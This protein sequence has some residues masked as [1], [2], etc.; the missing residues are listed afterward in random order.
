MALITSDFNHNHFVSGLVVLR[1]GQALYELS[2]CTMALITSDSVPS[3]PSQASW[4]FEEGKHGGTI[5]DIAI[6]GIDLVRSAVGESS[7]IY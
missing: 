1:G 2:S 7:V 4:Y 3:I 5:S 6:H